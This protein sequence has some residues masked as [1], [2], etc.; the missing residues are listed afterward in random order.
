MRI[1]YAKYDPTG[2]TTLLVT[3]PVPRSLQPALASRL[4]AGGETAAE[5]AGFLE[6]ASLPGAQARLQM[7]GGEFCGNASMALAA[8]LCAP[9]ADG[10][11]TRVVL[12]V[13]GAAGLV[14]VELENRAGRIFARVAMPLPRAIG[15]LRVEGQDWPLVEFDGISHLICPVPE[16]EGDVTDAQRALAFAAVRRVAATGACASGAVLLRGNT[17]R[18]APLVYVPASETFVWER[19]CGSGSAA[20]GAWLAAESGAGGVW[21]VSQPGG[22]IAV[23]VDWRG[24]ALAGID[25]E[26]EVRPLTCGCVD[27]EPAYGGR[28]CP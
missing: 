25:I 24:G 6:Q 27:A 7:M 8:H 9:K 19:G 11:R 28:D 20:V 23:R 15:S 10:D 22:E 4:I 18:I 26:G 1:S 14:G 13:S 2:N 21:R 16:G 5:Q 3:S 17:L 12:E